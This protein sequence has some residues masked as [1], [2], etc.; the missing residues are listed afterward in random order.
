M[1]DSV[2]LTRQELYELVWAEPIAKVGPKLGVSDTAVAKVC[3]KLNVPR[4]PRGYWARL[5][6]GYRVHKPPLPKATKNTPD[7]YLL[8]PISHRPKQVSLKNAPTPEL[9]ISASTGRY[10][11][12]VSEIRAD[13][14]GN[15]AD[16][17]GRIYSQYG[18]SVS[19]KN[20]KRTCRFL[21]TFVG[22]LT[23]LGFNFEVHKDR[24]CIVFD[25]VRLRL[26][27]H[28]P[29][30][31]IKPVVKDK[32]GYARRE[33]KPSGRITFKIWSSY[34]YGYRSEWS[35]GSKRL[36]EDRLQEVIG[37]VL[38][39]PDI[40]AAKKEKERKEEIARERR[41][42]CE[43]RRIDAHRGIHSRAET[44]GRLVDD[45]KKA[46][47][48]REFIDRVQSSDELPVSTLRVARWA[49]EYGDH[50][51]PLVD[52]R[53]AKLDQPVPEQRSNGWY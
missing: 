31:L 34:L 41:N 21:D 1:S 46:D 25:D 47:A 33:Y 9:K 43:R 28:E 12:L 29:A 10:H 16:Q 23:K 8:N 53:L 40:I 24:L 32:W 2:K 5:E 15:H 18:I 52:F 37:V 51:D 26:E 44:V 30:N 35:D 11:P 20:I 6:H 4:P 22:T 14:T 39:A 42:L 17:Y 7:S 49:K 27:I 13:L 50:L 38:K 45:L 48:I 3:R 36:L 19:K